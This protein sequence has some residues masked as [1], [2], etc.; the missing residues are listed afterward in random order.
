MDRLE[1]TRSAG[2][3]GGRGQHAD[4]AGEHG[5]LVAED[6]AEEVAGEDHVEL[7]RRPHQLH[8][9]VVHVH[10]AEGNIGV[11][12]GDRL[13]PVAPELAHIQHIGLVDRAEPAAALEGQIEAHPGDAIDLEVAVGHR[14]ERP[15]VAIGLHPA[16]GGS[17]VHAAGELAHHQ[18][19][20]PLNH[21]G[22]EAAGA[23][24]GG[25]DLHRPQIGKQT[26]ASP[27]AQQPRFGPFLAGQAVVLRAADGG[28][29]HRIGLPAGLQGAWGQGFAGGIDGGSPHRLLVVEKF[30][31]MAAAHRIQQLSGHRRDLRTDAVAGEQ[32]DPVAGHD[33]RRSGTVQVESARLGRSLWRTGLGA[34]QR[35]ELWWLEG[36]APRAVS[37]DS[38]EVVTVVLQR[39]PRL[40]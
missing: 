35:R 20:H 9:G 13:D 15:H 27:Q 34:C 40:D 4:R 2:A 11:V 22:F 25:D 29:Q 10:V 5:G 21:L 26:Q 30:E 31:T 1:Q 12:G 38:G 14:V 19:I 39:R 23:G 36:V 37:I 3:Q 24:Q 16:L 33:R 18:Q 28:E 7:L 8:R 32:G 17:E 6:V